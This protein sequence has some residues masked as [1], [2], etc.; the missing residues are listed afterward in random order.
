MVGCELQHQLQQASSVHGTPGGAAVA[1]QLDMSPQSRPSRQAGSYA[2]S[3]SL[4]LGGL[5]HE[6]QRLGH[7][8]AAWIALHKQPRA[9]YTRYPSGLS[10]HPPAEERL[11]HAQGD[12]GGVSHLQRLTQTLSSVDTFNPAGTGKR[13]GDKR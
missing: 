5:P 10:L 11:R 4:M 9:G 2:F 3:E 1:H 8:A 12:G 6:A 7:L 13:G